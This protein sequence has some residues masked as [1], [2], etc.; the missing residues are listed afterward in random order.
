MHICFVT[1]YT[2]GLDAIWFVSDTFGFN[3]FEKH[4]FQR[5]HSEFDGYVR[6]NFEINGYFNNK[7][8]NMDSSIFGRQRNLI[9]S[10]VN[11][12]KYLPKLV[13]LVPDDD[14]VDYLATKRD[15]SFLAGRMIDWMMKQCSRIVMARKEFLQSKTKRNNF[16]HFVWIEAPLH[17]FFKNND[18]RRKFN[19]CLKAMGKLHDDVSVL[20]LKKVW[21]PE[22]TSL[23][24]KDANMFSSKGF[25]K[26]WEAVDR[27]IKFADT[28]IVKRIEKLNLKGFDV[29][30]KSSRNAVTN[31]KTSYDKYHWRPTPAKK[32]NSFGKFNKFKDNRKDG[33]AFDTYGKC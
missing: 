30:D 17:I 20:E 3:S 12:N 27:S 29:A 10:A 33:S 13:V 11:E 1:D 5:K 16:P 22:D 9:V 6:E 23:Y 7:N 26:Y 32:Q 31:A 18:E 2:K 21:D 14:I 25:N 28:T 24:V 8:N 15:L 19:D 4:Y